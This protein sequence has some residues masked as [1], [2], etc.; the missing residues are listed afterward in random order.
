MDS[1]GA[2]ST[3]RETLKNHRVFPLVAGFLMLLLGVSIYWPSLEGTPI[4]DDLYLVGAN[5]FFR[6]PIFVIEVFKQHLFFGFPSS[7]YRPVQN[8][9]YIFDYWFWGGIPFG[10][11]LTNVLLHTTAAWLLYRVLARVLIPVIRKESFKVQ[12][13]A[14][15]VAV[16]WLVH[17]I[18]NAAVSYISGRAD[19]LA[20]IFALS[21]WLLVLKAQNA[22]SNLRRTIW[23]LLAM[24]TAVL[25]LASKEIGLIWMVLFIVWGWTCQ[26]ASTRTR[27]WQCAGVA[28]VV[29]IYALLHSIPEARTNVTPIIPE[30]FTTRVL[31]MLKALGAY[32]GLLIFPKTLMMERTV[33]LWG[34][35]DSKERWYQN[36][37]YE[38]LSIL[39]ILAV[40]LV[41]IL[42]RNKGEGKYL[43]WFGIAWFGIT[44]FPISNL[45]PLNAQLAEHWIYLA[46]IGLILFA[47]GTALLIPRRFYRSMLVVF[48]AG[49]LAYGTRTWVRACDWVNAEVFC[50]RTIQDGGGTSRMLAYLSEEFGRK[51]QWD[52]Q[53][54]ILR[55]TLEIYPDYATARIAL[56]ICLQRQGRDKE[57]ESYLAGQNIETAKAAPLPTEGWAASLN[58]A[59]IRRGAGQAAEAIKILEDA[60][61]QFPHQWELVLAHTMLLEEVEG[62]RRAMALPVSYVEKHWWHLPAR[63]KLADLQHAIGDID[64]AIATL[65]FAASL[66][67]HSSTAYAVMSG[68]QMDAGRL[69]D[70]LASQQ[71]AVNRVPN[72]PRLHL[73][74]ANILH[75]LGRPQEAKEALAKAAALR[76]AG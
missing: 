12:I 33:D 73:S 76:A 35:Y 44:F 2:H 23:I 42:C 60:R 74:L 55:R 61:L 41:V 50:F 24:I 45:I 58:L 29:G 66:D 53:E 40:S 75:R 18:H 30:P 14:L 67:V 6:S 9:S 39:G 37:Y 71:K 1:A 70:A 7:Y 62:P 3:F 49:I 21:A 13:I 34:M 57:A 19:S 4:W 59:S 36:L 48:A 69:A 63:L 27:I 68:I 26:S 15:G 32:A 56:G 54:M 20:M 8:L 47:A 65:E 5:P 28:V 10:Y 72:D 38:Y 11:H 52:R 51:Q 31:F 16:F 25:S 22:N 43:R 46:S 17:P 64:A